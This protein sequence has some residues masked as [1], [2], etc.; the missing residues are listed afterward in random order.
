MVLENSHSH[1]QYMRKM[2]L[3]ILAVVKTEF[4][5]F[6]CLIIEYPWHMPKSG[7]TLIIKATKRGGSG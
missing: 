7:G 2:A 3:W 4:S 6:S 1:K 5:S